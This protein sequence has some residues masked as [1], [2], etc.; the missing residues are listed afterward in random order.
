MKHL[1][2]TAK[3][4]QRV[5]GGQEGRL[6]LRRTRLKEGKRCRRNRCLGKGGINLH[7]QKDMFRSE[8]L[9]LKQ[10]ETASSLLPLGL[11]GV[12]RGMKRGN[13]EGRGAAQGMQ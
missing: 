2:K 12:A 13:S 5:A 7:R 4:S 6:L 10:N 1:K 8:S 3:S 9:N 11:A